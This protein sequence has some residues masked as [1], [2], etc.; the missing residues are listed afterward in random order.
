MEGRALEERKRKKSCL[1]V[2][3]PYGWIILMFGRNQ[4]NTLMQLS[5]FKKM[6]EAK[7]KWDLTTFLAKTETT[8]SRHVQ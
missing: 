6:N 2:G 1:K 7:K 4:H 5:L 8:Q 3:F